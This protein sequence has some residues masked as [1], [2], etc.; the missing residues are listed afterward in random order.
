MS[1]HRQAA[2]VDKNQ[3]GLVHILRRIPGV[4][5]AVGH[6]DI[7]V[8]VNGR[9]YWLELKTP[10]CV[11]KDGKIRE[12]EIT[13]S[14]KELRKHW[15]GHYCIVSSLEEILVECGLTKKKVDLP[16]TM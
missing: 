1:K 12:S 14:E 13:D 2:R 10:E 9:T 7:L 4:T 5:V 15:R 16:A 6:D 11:G 3:T 8:G